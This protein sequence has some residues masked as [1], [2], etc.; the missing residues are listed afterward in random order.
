[1][2]TITEKAGDYLN[3]VVGQAEVPEGNTIR[4]YAADGQLQ[5]AFDSPQDGDETFDHEGKT[6]LIVEKPL[7][8][9]LEGRTLDIKTGEQGVSLVL[10]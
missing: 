6:V 2:L 3:Q 4:L 10:A 8:E 7:A 5:I 1:M 9:G